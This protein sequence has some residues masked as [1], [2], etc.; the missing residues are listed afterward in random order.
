MGVTSRVKVPNGGWR[1]PAVSQK[2]GCPSRGGWNRQI[3]SEIHA[4]RTVRAL[5]DA[6]RLFI[7]RSEVCFE[8]AENAE[9][10]WAVSEKTTHRSSCF[11]NSPTK[12]INKIPTCY[13]ENVTGTGLM[14]HLLSIT[15]FPWH[16]PN[17]TNN[18]RIRWIL[19]WFLGTV[20]R[21]YLLMVAFFVFKVNVKN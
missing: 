16:F 15:P 3:P 20:K 13:W 9:E 11:T 1:A 4:F 8:K 18:P 5:F 6:I 21:F 14:T 2:Q 7:P 19:G 17:K 10:R 12:K